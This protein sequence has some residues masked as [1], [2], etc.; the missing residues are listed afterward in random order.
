[1]ESIHRQ[2]RLRLYISGIGQLLQEVHSKHVYPGKST[3]ECAKSIQDLK[4]TSV[5]A[6]Y[7]L[8]EVHL[9]VHA[10]PFGLGAVTSHITE[11]GEEHPIAYAS[12]EWYIWN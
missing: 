1:M 12:C 4:N 3:Q 7:N 11:E 6:H 10:S 5:Y 9:A 8:L 2:P